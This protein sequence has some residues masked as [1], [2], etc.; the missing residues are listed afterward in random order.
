MRSLREVSAVFRRTFLCT[1]S[2]SQ[3]PVFNTRAR[4]LAFAS[5]VSC[6]ACFYS[7]LGRYEEMMMGLVSNNGPE[8]WRLSEKSWYSLC[9]DDKWSRSEG[10]G[11]LMLDGLG[12]VMRADNLGRVGFGFSGDVWGMVAY[13]VVG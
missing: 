5:Y 9:R 13:E 7:S 3:L 4:G 12:G 1:L 2:W 8:V 10:V 6:L 11:V